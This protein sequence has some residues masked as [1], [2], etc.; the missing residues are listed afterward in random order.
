MSDPIF[1]HE[2]AVMQT[3]RTRAKADAHGVLHLDIRAG[4]PDFEYEVVV[5]L[6]PKAGVAIQP[7]ASESRS[8]T[9]EELG[10]PP[11]FFEETAGAWQ[12]DFIRDQGQFEERDEL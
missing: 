2:A 4:T 12:G 7:K 6:Q 11:N 3:L 1:H 9:P 10:W 8:E 5:V